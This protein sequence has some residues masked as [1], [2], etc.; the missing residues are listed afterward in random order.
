MNAVE[1]LAYYSDGSLPQEAAYEVK[2]TEPP[3]EWSQEGSITLDKIV[4]SY[5]PGL[6]PVL[7]GL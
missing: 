5:R 1:R 4:M 7:K 6:P 3:A 2:E